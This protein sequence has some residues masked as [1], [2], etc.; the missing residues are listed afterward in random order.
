MNFAQQIILIFKEKILNL[1]GWLELILKPV[2]D[3][4][5]KYRLEKIEIKEQNESCYSIVHYKLVGCRRLE[6]QSAV[7][8]NK[9]SLFAMFRA[10]HAQIIVSI[11]TVET[12]INLSKNELL[13]KYREYIDSCNLRLDG[14]N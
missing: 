8:L 13:H 2:F 1:F 6:S 9:S 11:A 3:H 7:E 4:R 10:D 12:L 14:Q 5:Y